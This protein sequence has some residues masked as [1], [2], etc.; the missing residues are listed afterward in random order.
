MCFQSYIFSSEVGSGEDCEDWKAFPTGEWLKK[1]KP[2]A[3]FALALPVRERR[4]FKCNLKVS[5]GII[6]WIIWTLRRVGWK[7]LKVLAVK[8]VR[9]WNNI[10]LGILRQCYLAAFGFELNNI[11]YE[12]DFNLM[13]YVIVDNS[14]VFFC[15]FFNGIGLIL[16]VQCVLFGF[17]CL[18]GV[19]K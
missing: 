3:W 14:E 12:K 6:M 13:L 1:N 9:C 15:M 7:L 10:P 18:T 8:P 5:V 4:E 17:H 16:C 19:F 11:Y 2:K